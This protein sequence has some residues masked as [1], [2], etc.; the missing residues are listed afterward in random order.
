MYINWLWFGSV[1]FRGVYTT[2]FWTR[3]ALFFIFGMIMAAG[4]GA[5]L[6]IAYHAR[7]PF[8][9]LSPEQQNLERYR[10]I[11]EPRKKLLFAVLLSSSASRRAWPRRATGR[12]GSSG[13]TAARSAV[14]DPQF[15]RDISFFAWDYP[16]YRTMLSFGFALVIFSIIL[17]VAV[18]YIFGAIRIQTPGPKIT[19]SARR[20]LTILIFVFIVFKAIAYWLDRYGL[21]YSDR[22][23]VTGASYTDVNASL[24]AKTILFW[25]AL[26]IAILVIASLWL[27]SARLPGIAFV[28]LLILSIVINGIYPAIVQQV[29]VKPNASQ[30]EAPYISRNIA[31]TRAAYDI[32]ST[33]AGGHDRLRSPT[34]SRPRPI[35]VALVEHRARRSATSASSTRTSC[36]R[37]SPSSSSCAT[38]TGS[39]EQARRRPL[40][41]RRHH[42]RLRRRRPRAEG[43]EPDLERH[44]RQP[45]QLDQQPHRLHARLRVR[46]RRRPVP[47]SRRPAPTPRATSRRPGPLDAEE[48]GRLLRRA[49]AG[50]LDRR[51]RRHAARDTTAAARPRSPIR[52]RGGVSLGNFFTRFAFALNYKETN[53]LLNDSVSAKGAKIIFNRDPRQIVQKVAPFLKVDSDPYPFVDSATRRHRLDDRR[54]HDDVELPVL[55]AG[56]A[57]DADLGLAVGDEQDREPA[58]RPDQLHPQLGQG[59]GRRLHRQG[60]ALRTGTTATRCSRPG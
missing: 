7:P 42:P 4:I 41:H 2:V 47:T 34:T 14:K 49:A 37:R 46:R 8:R 23:N 5:S 6:V 3:V 26:I 53:F 50:L 28:V 32:N 17:S 22:G 1:G 30:K 57:V 16:A 9:P 52:A 39:R 19:L 11:L 60:H 56:I 13:S 10:V 20:H 40:R 25:I 27:K 54:L 24:P 51:R 59:D 43:S 33:T 18:Y 15:H 44:Q 38:S 35:T 29:T 45:E 36:R 55:R 21:V 58:Q 31:A 48:P 12:S